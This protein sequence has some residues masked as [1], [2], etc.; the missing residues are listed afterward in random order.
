MLGMS[1]SAN[2]DETIFERLDELDLG[3]IRTGT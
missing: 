1:D 3:R 2:R